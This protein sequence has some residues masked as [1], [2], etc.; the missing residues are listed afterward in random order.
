[1]IA[2]IRQWIA[3][4]IGLVAA[5]AGAWLRVFAKDIAAPKLKSYSWSGPWK[6]TVW[7][8]KEQAYLELGRIFLFFG[9][10]VMLVA[11][12]NFLW[13]NEAHHKTALEDV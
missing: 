8:F 6:D 3:F 12:I 5:G 1:M 7:G 11:L 9:L 2:R 10:I 4:A 13:S